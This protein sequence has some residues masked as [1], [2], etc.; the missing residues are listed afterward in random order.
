MDSTVVTDGDTG[1]VICTRCGSVLAEKIESL[2]PE[3]YSRSN[4]Q[5]MGRSR[6]GGK[7][8]LAIDDMGLSTIISSKN[9]DATGKSLTWDMRNTFN[10]LRMWDSR[11]KSRS[12][13]RS[14]RTAFVLLNTLKEKLAIPDT[15]IEKTAYLYRKALAK[16]L[17]RGRNISALVAAAL[18]IACKEAN[19]PRTLNDIS[20]ASDLKVN[21]VSKHLRLLVES[22]ELRLASYDSSDFVSRIASSVGIGEKTQR[23]A[24]AILATAKEKGLI[25]GKNPIAM[26]ATSLYLSSV[27]NKE[28]RT[29][30]EIARASGISE[31]TIRSRTRFL[32]DVLKLQGFVV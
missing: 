12:V 32:I 3:H 20:Q 21:D 31:V 5:Y 23:D 11:S 26:A 16:K 13:E 7:S 24:L 19:I 14:L 15:V 9:E 4:E 8:T 28:C 29:Q 22:L 10:R 1:E 18:Y 25:E 30:R 17:T 6:T 27:M 2:S